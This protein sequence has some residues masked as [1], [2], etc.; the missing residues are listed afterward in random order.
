MYLLHV[1]ETLL[2]FSELSG[3]FV[4]VLTDGFQ[5]PLQVEGCLLLVGS[6]H[7]AAH[8]TLGQLARLRLQHRHLLAQHPVLRPQSLHNPIFLIFISFLIKSECE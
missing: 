6:A 7:L 8:Q 5:L 3:C 1:F 2:E 4:V